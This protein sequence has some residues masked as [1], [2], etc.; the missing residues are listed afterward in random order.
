MHA[1]TCVAAALSA[2]S[3]GTTIPMVHLALPSQY[4]TRRSRTG[5]VSASTNS[6]R[7]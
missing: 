5:K 7:L 2:V 4:L 3:F 1:K 6:G